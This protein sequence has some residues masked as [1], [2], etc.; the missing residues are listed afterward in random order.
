[1]KRL[2]FIC[3]L[4]LTSCDA[5][6]SNWESEKFSQQGNQYFEICCVSRTSHP[7]DLLAAVQQLAKMCHVEVKIEFKSGERQ[8]YILITARGNSAA[9]VNNFLEQL[10]DLEYKI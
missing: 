6:P 3:L 9:K 4:L 10:K 5:P 8:T 1:M 7:K 2:F